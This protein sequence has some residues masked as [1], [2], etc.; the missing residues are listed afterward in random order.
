[1]NKLFK[2]LLILVFFASYSIGQSVQNENTAKEFEFRVGISAKLFLIPQ[3]SLFFP[4]S[5]LSTDFYQQNFGL[6]PLPSH[7]DNGVATGQ[8]AGN[9]AVNSYSINSKLQFELGVDLGYQN[10]ELSSDKIINRVTTVDTTYE[11]AS[12]S[13]KYNLHEISTG[14]YFLAKTNNTFLNFYFGLGIGHYFSIGNVQVSNI[15]LGNTIETY[16]TKFRKYS[17][18]TPYLP[19]GLEIPLSQKRKN[20]FIKVMGSI[21][22]EKHTHNYKQERFFLT[23]GIQFQYKF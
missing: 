4:E 19:I 2:T 3:R 10:S 18:L 5:T 8:I 15:L 13:L 12:I 22:L 16:Q 9:F 17:N 1:M 21:R 7:K 14:L 23:G 11:Y 20:I 6:A